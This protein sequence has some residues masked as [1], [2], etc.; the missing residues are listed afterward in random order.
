MKFSFAK[1]LITPNKK[2]SLACCPPYDRPYLEIHDDIYA[3]G[4]YMEDE[5][6][7]KTLLLSFDL[8]F[9]NDL[10]NKTL[11]DYA[12]RTYGVPKAAVLVNYTH[13]HTA[14]AAA[15]YGDTLT[16]PEYEEFLV[17]RALS[18]IDR[19]FTTIMEGDVSYENVPCDWSM[20]R[21]KIVD[22][23]CGD[24]APSPD[25]IRE[26]T[27]D[28]LKFTDTSGKIRGLI[29]DYATHPVHYPGESTISGE[30][31]ARLVSLLE[32]EY[33]GASALFLQ[34]AAA[35][36]RPR[37]TVNGDRFRAPCDYSDVDMLATALFQTV[38][39][40][41]C[42]RNWSPLTLDI[43]AAADAI[44]LDMEKQPYAYFAEKEKLDLGFINNSSLKYILQNYQTM[45]D[46]I[47]LNVGMIR[48]TKDLYFCH[49]GGEPGMEM[50]ALLEALFPHIKIIFVGYTDAISY[51]PTNQM[52]SEGGY[53]STCFIE[54]AK[55]G[56]FKPEIDQK[57]KT[58][59]QKMFE[60][61]S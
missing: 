22:G 28:V 1:E 7:G 16:S 35:T 9:H 50:K 6:G 31:P 21:R 24:M 61:L 55:L 20:S 57:V 34:G 48:L 8:L 26:K 41:L 10:L 23:K 60:V 36:S 44:Q 58:S 40:A 43:G 29:V 45:D 33:Y 37:T 25:N 46:F 13:A 19:I 3:R 53:E 4:C 11:A 14:P 51:I 32:C 5:K 54:Y 17:T 18:L 56:P 49:M 42:S 47:L 2:C 59:F 27:M 52:L 38:K 15:G 30:Y 39:T 12:E